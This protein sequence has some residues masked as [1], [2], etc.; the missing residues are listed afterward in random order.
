M[1]IIGKCLTANEFKKYVENKSFGILPAN[2][3]I[4]HHTY[5]PNLSQWKGL[6][7]IM[8]M[9][10]VYEG[11]KWKAGPHLYIAPEGIWLFSDMAK[12]GVHAGSGNWRSIG[13]EMV[14]DYSFN[15]PKGMVWELTKYAITILNNKLKL[16]PENI[17]LHR[18]FS[19]TECPG[20]AINKLWVIDELVNYNI[21]PP[22]R[23]FVKTN[24]KK[25]VFFVK[26]MTAYPI[27]DWDTFIFYWGEPS[28]I[29]TITDE[30]LSSLKIG[31][32]LPSF[33]G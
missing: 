32:T 30:V 22:D 24:T 23:S 13:I 25:A 3:T 5:I 31:A 11:K 10:K 12:D 20:K 2:K 16:L 19:D 7:S 1:E 17:K 18:E 21:L 14:G 29:I 33:K 28:K 15:K 4:L 27:P 26:N 6:S 9:K 8:A